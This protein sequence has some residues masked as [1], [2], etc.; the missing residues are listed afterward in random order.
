MHTTIRRYDGLDPTTVE[1]IIQRVE[2]G[3]LPIVSAVEGFISF[4]YIDAGGGVIATISTFETQAAAEQSNKAAEGWVK[5]NLS[6]FN[7]TLPQITAGE[8]RI[9]K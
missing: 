9:D 8:V 4:R 3:F 2:S 6:E 5:E 1:G 7:P